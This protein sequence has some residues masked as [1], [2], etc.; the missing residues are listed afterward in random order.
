M[1]TF[2]EKLFLLAA[3]ASLGSCLTTTS[4]TGVERVAVDEVYDLTGKWNDIDSQEGANTIIDKALSGPWLERWQGTEPP[5]LIVGNVRNNT[6]E[7]IDT[8]LFVKDIEAE[9]INSGQ[10]SFVASSE[11][12]GQVRNEREDQQSNASEATIKRIAQETGADFML[13]GSIDSSVEESIG[14]KVVYYRLGMELIDLESNVKAWVGSHRIKKVI[15]KTAQERNNSR[16]RR[17]RDW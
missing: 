6:S 14:T 2:I 10:V 1:R 3:L 12:R 11:E 16:E 7:H 9:L 8:Q 17:N 13:I 15:N 4:S 5:V